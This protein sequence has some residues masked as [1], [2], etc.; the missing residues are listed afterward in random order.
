MMMTMT[1]EQPL[2]PGPLSLVPLL[3]VHVH[4]HVPSH[5]GGLASPWTMGMASNALQ[6]HEC[7]AEVATFVNLIRA[8]HRDYRGVRQV[9]EGAGVL[10]L[11]KWGSIYMHE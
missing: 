5:H 9:T 1:E 11:F 4:I 8:G 3:K 6:L 7:I 10:Q 2:G